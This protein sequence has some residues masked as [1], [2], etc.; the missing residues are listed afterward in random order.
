MSWW[1]A[2]FRLFWINT[3]RMKKKSWKKCHQKWPLWKWAKNQL[4]SRGQRS[5]WNRSTRTWLARRSTAD[6]WDS[7]TQV[8]TKKS[9][10]NKNWSRPCV[11]RLDSAMSVAISKI[12]FS[13]MMKSKKSTISPA[14]S[15]W[16]AVPQVA[17]KVFS[18]TQKSLL[19]GR[20]LAQRIWPL[21][22]VNF[23]QCTI[24]LSPLIIRL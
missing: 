21:A 14:P 10:S 16:G 13:M 11:S 8:C 9:K 3:R 22:P 17:I 23:W 15:W 1:S 6:S 18:L 2:T 19:W 4:K 24:R 12:W 20:Q 7:L 5:C